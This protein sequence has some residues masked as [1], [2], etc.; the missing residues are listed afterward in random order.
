MLL[1]FVNKILSTHE[2]M[3]SFY[4]RR[5]VMKRP[6]DTHFKENILR[7]HVSTLIRDPA[8]VR[9]P[10]LIRDPLLI[11]DPALITDPA[12]IGDPALF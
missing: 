7:Y 6:F 10:T 11:G 12:L 3:F 8:L 9:N 5:E 1:M 4:C 2:F